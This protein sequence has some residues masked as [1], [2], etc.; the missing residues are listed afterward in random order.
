MLVFGSKVQDHLGLY[1]PHSIEMNVSFQQFHSFKTEMKNNVCLYLTLKV[2]H[3][4]VTYFSMESRFS[5]VS[6]ILL[7]N[8]LCFS[9]CSMSKFE[10]VHFS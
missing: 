9:Y 10:R 4:T 2:Y 8:T 5:P 6:D 1:P 7:V 3:L